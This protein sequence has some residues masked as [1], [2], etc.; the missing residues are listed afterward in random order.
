MLKGMSDSEKLTYL[1]NT[2][3][4]GMYYVAK[5]LLNDSHISEDVV[6][7]VMLRISREDIL[8]K[9]ENMDEKA[10]KYYLY[11]AARNLATN[12]YQKRKREA[13]VTIGSY[14]EEMVNNI[15]V[16]DS[17]ETVIRK[18]EEEAFFKIVRELPHKYSDILIVKYKYGFSDKQIAQSYGIKE[19]TVRKRLERGRK[20]LLEQLKKQHYLDDWPCGMWREELK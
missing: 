5:Q 12:M 17:A 9:L 7:E 1:F 16:E 8:K 14:N 6:Q 13:G 4:R 3:G 10:V 2:F 18:L 19:A 11:T 15:A 20:M